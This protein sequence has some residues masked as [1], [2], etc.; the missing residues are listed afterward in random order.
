MTSYFKTWRV[1]FK[2]R[3]V[4]QLMRMAS[5]YTPQHIVRFEKA[6]SFQSGYSSAKAGWAG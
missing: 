5:A 4:E 3:R 2:G 1:Q 6:G